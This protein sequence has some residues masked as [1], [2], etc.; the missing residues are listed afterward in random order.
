MSL[1]L[2]VAILCG[3]RGTRLGALTENTPKSLVKVAG[4]PFIEWQLDIL[5]NQGV[6][7]VVLCVS[8]LGEQ[9]IAFAAA[10]S[11][12]ICIK[13]VWD[14]PY[15]LGQLGAVRHVAEMTGWLEFL[16]LYGDSY[17]DTDYAPIVAKGRAIGRPVQAVFNDH[18][19]GLTYM[20]AEAIAKM[21]PYATMSNLTAHGFA[22]PFPMPKRWMQMGDLDG[23]A[24]VHW[25]L[26][27]KGDFT[28]RYLKETQDVASL[29]D[30]DKIE[31]IVEH[32]VMLRERKGRLWIIGNGGSASNASHAA[33]DLRKFCS[34]EAYSAS[35]NIGELTANASGWRS[36]F[37]NFLKSS[38]MSARD[39]LLVLSVGGGIDVAPATSVNIAFAVQYANRIGTAVLS[40]VGRDGG[41][42]GQHS[43]VCLLVPPI[44]KEWITPM[45]E[46]MQAVVWHLLANHPRLRVSQ[47][48]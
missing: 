29:L 5:K 35:D 13:C 17:L 4:R 3:G 32:L 10:H 8:H 40:V 14:D 20:T 16:V 48:A 7:T 11:G 30:H 41:Y 34:I 9:L 45:Q 46:T 12:D 37:A 15:P 25:M 22:E 43:T 38:N 1:D 28:A 18:D 39:C 42:C 27:N 26:C 23:L 36:V 24:E 21:P 44:T 31:G 33:N 6:K 2:P 47:C 19:Y